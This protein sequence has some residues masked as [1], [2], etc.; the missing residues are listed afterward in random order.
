MLVVTFSWNAMLIGIII[1][2]VQSTRMSASALQ[3]LPA[4]VVFDEQLAG[5]AISQQAGQHWSIP[6]L[7]G[8]PASGDYIGVANVEVAG[9]TD[10]AHICLATSVPRRL[11]SWAG[12]L[13]LAK[14]SSGETGGK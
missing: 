5:S 9:V 13:G 8:T 4:N 2:W 14:S 1:R 11:T 6:Y 12:V 10:S 3:G 7:G